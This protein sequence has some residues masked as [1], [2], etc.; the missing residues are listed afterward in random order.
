MRIHI[1]EIKFEG[2]TPWIKAMN[3]ASEYWNKY[4]DESLTKKEKD[5]A[6]ECWS[7]IRYEIETGK[8]GNNS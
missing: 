8:Y 6:Y 3:Q 4:C 5:D 7:Q 2:D 1:N